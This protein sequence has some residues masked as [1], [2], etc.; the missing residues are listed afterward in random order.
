MSVDL[1]EIFF[2]GPSKHRYLGVGTDTSYWTKANRTERK[3]V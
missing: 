1:M 2:C 3:D